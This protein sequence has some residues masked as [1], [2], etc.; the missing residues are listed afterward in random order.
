VVIVYTLTT[1]WPAALRRRLGDN[2]SRNVSS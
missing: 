2:Y 1:G